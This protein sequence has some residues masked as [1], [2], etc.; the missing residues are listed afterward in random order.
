MNQNAKTQKH[1]MTK[2]LLNQ[3]FKMIRK[4]NKSRRQICRK[5]SLLTKTYSLG[6]IIMFSSQ[7]QAK[8]DKERLLKFSKFRRG[9]ARVMQT[10]STHHLIIINL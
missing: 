10:L 2:K 7:I 1:K 5:K 4:K 8:W 3:K 6:S 9:I